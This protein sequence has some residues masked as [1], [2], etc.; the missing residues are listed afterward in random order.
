MEYTGLIRQYDPIFRIGV[1][2]G[3]LHEQWCN[4]PC[5]YYQYDNNLQAR[6]WL[7]SKEF[8]NQE[9]G[10][11]TTPIEDVCS[12]SLRVQL[13][14]IVPGSVK[15]TV[16]PEAIKLQ[17]IMKRD[18]MQKMD[19]WM[20]LKEM[21]LY[22]SERSQERYIVIYIWKSLEDLA[23][24]FAINLRTRRN[25]TIPKSPSSSLK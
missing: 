20:W 19:F 6:C 5:A 15:Q 17:Y 1:W 24:N 7:N 21:C 8:E 13:P 14:A 4:I 3:D 18:S 10:R 25:N 12:L 2:T 23:V 9:K 11:P 16:E 22:S